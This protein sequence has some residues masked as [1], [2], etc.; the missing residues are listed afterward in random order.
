MRYALRN[1][2]KLKAHFGEQG[3]QMLERL[4]KSLAK[5][6]KENEDIEAT[7]IQVEGE[8]YPIIVVEDAGCSNGLIAFYLVK[9][10]YY[11][12]WVVAFKEFV[13]S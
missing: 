2:D 13:Q 10:T 4:H 6:F 1:Q 11:D 5:A 3:E 8:P 7:A 9:N 12:V